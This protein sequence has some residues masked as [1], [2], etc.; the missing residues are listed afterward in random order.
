[1]QFKVLEID[2]RL[3]SQTPTAVLKSTGINML[4]MLAD[5]YVNGISPGIPE[6]AGEKGVVYEHIKVTRDVIEVSGEHI[7][8][9]KG[10]LHFTENFFGANEA[11]TNYTPTSSQWVATMIF[12]EVT[13]EEAWEKRCAAVDHI[14]KNF[15]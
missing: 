8:S 4:K 1:N 15:I 13:I 9:D 2:A 5:V 3:P 14:M 11:I 12:T 6:T 7:M 10:P